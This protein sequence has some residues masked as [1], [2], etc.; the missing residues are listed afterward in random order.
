M[1]N[2]EEAQARLKGIF[3]ITMTPF[4]KD[5]ALDKA[6]LARN[7]ERVIEL[8]YDGVLIGGTY[9]EFPTMTVAER[10]E[11]FTHVMDVIGDRIP[12][13]LCS[14]GSDPRDVFELTKL[15]GDLGGVPMVT[16][17]FVSEIT[18]DQIVEFF[19]EVA[20]LSK[21]GIIIYNAPGIGITLSPALIERL[22][23]ID[24]MVGLKQG[25]LNPT[26][27]DRIAN[28]LRGRVKTFC[29]SDLAFLGPVM[30]GFDGFSTTNSGA[31]PEL[32]L[33]TYQA[34]EAGDAAKARELHALWYDYRALARAH[35]QPQLVKAAMNMR[36][37]DGG[38]VRLPLR[39][40]P[41]SVLPKL[42]AVMERLAADA[43]AGLK[44]AA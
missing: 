34:V 25:D 43:R 27:I 35:G 16:A 28:S 37:F 41:D 11:I 22:A 33:A 44:L 7:V 2:R 4:A 9:G 18:D 14:A 31:L 36:G 30:T 13:M 3:N 24:G 32:I 8:G 39:D 17:P 1:Q 6:G 42:R 29:A 38:S 10:A 23:D 26:A 20:P 21:T 15:A 12:A 19:R 5:G 40:V